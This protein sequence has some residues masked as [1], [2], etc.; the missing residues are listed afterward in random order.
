MRLRR[1]VS[2]AAAA[3]GEQRDERVVSAMQAERRRQR[4]ERVERASE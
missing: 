4:E 3:V 2:G 1:R